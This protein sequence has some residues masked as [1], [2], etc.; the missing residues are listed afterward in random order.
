M[1]IYN[2]YCTS[3]STESQEENIFLILLHIIGLA[4]MPYQAK[5]ILLW[6]LDVLNL[7]FQLHMEASYD[8]LKYNLYIHSIL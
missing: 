3:D 6:K 7:M 4:S 8:K 2:I 1:C 5:Y